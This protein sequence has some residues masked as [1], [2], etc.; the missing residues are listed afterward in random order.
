[1]LARALVALAVISSSGLALAA[2]DA[3]GCKDPGLFSRLPSFHIYSCKANDFD[4]AKFYVARDKQ[5][6]VE[7]KLSETN[8]ALDDG[9]KPLSGLAI[10]RNFQN[11]ARKIGG[12]TVYQWEDGGLV[13]TTLRVKQGGKDVWVDVSEIVGG[14][15]L[16]ILERAAMEQQLTADAAALKAGLAEVGHVEVP[17]ILFDTGKA[18]LKPESDAA[19]GECAKL[20]AQDPTLKVYVVGHTDNQGPLASNL[21]LSAARADA[22]VKA[23]VARFKVAT[24][25]LAPF[26]AGPHAPV[27][28][29]RAE[30]GRAK[31]RRVELVAQ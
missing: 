19:L 25:R 21:T 24:A 18:T 8:Y 15:Y 27:A 22:V 31:N 17:G 5:E 2:E 6:T 9:A 11:A 12:S 1:M 3:E 28:S 4:Q 29:N 13:G 10:I 30:E 14:F 23:L 7:G 26:G 16:V 20:L